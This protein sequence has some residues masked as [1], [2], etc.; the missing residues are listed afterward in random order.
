MRFD[1]CGLTVFQDKV[2]GWQVGDEGGARG[3]MCAIL[4]EV[5]R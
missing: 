4:R 1:E 3:P 2:L 5:E